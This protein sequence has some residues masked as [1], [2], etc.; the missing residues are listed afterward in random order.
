MNS[1]MPIWMMRLDV[2]G[3]HREQVR[4]DEPAKAGVAQRALHVALA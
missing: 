1:A 4:R 3:H 2:V